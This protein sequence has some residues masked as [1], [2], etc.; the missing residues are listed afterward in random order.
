VSLS[1]RLC[2]SMTLPVSMDMLYLVMRDLQKHAGGY[3]A[4][5]TAWSAAC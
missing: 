3:R 1:P 2:C 4:Q 5:C